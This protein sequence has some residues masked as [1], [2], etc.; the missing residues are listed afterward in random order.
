MPL[1]VSLR[2]VV[3]E[4]DIGGS[5]ATAYINRVTGDLMTVLHDEMAMIEDGESV[6]D[7]PDWQQEI[8][9]RVA[10]VAESED[11]L[12]LPSSLDINEYEIMVRFCHTVEDDR[13]AADLRQH[14]HR[15]RAFS[16]FKDALHR[17]GVADDW[18]AYRQ[19]AFEEIAVA[20]LDENG[21]AFVRGAD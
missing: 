9:Q 6:D 16:R 13:L 20:W 4:M 5:E 14:L 17:H 15:S 7:M 18:F 19:R 21:I 1:P 3:D 11:F 10:A 2:N 12:P 8:M